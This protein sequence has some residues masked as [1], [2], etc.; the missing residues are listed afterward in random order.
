MLTHLVAPVTKAVCDTFVT[1]KHY[2]RRA[3]VFQFGFGLIA[4]DQSIQG[5]VVFGMPPVQIAK[6]AF[7]DRDFPLYELTRLVVQTKEKNA[8][9]FLISHGLRGLP[10]PSAVISYADSEQS[11]C[12][13]VYQATNWA[14]TG[15][16]VSHD[17]MYLIDGVRV[18]PRTL[19]A[20]GIKS[21]KTWAK[22]NGI[23]TV[24]PMP[25]HRYFYFNGDKRQV[26][27]MKERLKYPI[28][29]EY[30]KSDQKRYDDGPEVHVTLPH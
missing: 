13:I 10:K 28:V 12:G 8:A 2:S 4:E 27:S 11:H 30:P 15:A 14:Y 25:K 9:S 24:A 18:H 5:V 19:A 16:T 21:P 6:H 23:T 29:P 7:K 26:R 1:Q 22:E 17:S 3:S 20:R